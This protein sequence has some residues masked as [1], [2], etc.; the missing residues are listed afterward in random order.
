M[1]GVDYLL[2]SLWPVPDL[3]S[4]DFMHTFYTA[5]ISRR[6]I[7][8]AFE[9]ARNKMRREYHGTHLWGAWELIK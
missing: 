8:Q 7:Q 3:E 9:I 5:W 2:V 1:A 6:N 4:A